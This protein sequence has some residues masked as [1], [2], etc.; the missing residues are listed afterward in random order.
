MFFTFLKL[1]YSKRYFV[2]FGGH[3]GFAVAILK[4]NLVIGLDNE[5][6]ETL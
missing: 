1:F 2:L 6:L 5:R 3:E 4:H